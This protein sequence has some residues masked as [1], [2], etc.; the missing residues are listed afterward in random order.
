MALQTRKPTGAVPYPL[1]LVEGPEKCGKSWDLAVLSSSPRVGRTFWIDLGEGAGD[2][3]GAIP[4][5]RY[6]VVLHDGT[7]KSIIEAVEEIRDIAR[8]AADAGEPPVVIGIDS[9]TLIWDMLKDWVTNRARKAP[10]NQ[11]LLREDPNAEINISSNFWNDANARHRRLMT[12]LMTF[13]GIAVVT[14]RGKEVTAMKNGSPDPRAPKEYRV[15]GQKDLA[16]DASVWL[17]LS[18]TE[19]PLIVGARSVHAGIKVGED[20]PRRVPGLTLESLIFDI[21]KCDPSAARVRDLVELQPGNAGPDGEPAV[22]TP[23]TTAP[24][25]R[26]ARAREL[27]TEITTANSK[28]ALSAA[29][30]ATASAEKADEI[31]KAESGQLVTAWHARKAVVTKAEALVTT[32]EADRDSNPGQWDVIAANWSKLGYADAARLA[33]T[34]E[35]LGVEALP[36]GWSMDKLKFRQATAIMDWQT[37][38]SWDLNDQPASTTAP[39]ELNGTARKRMHALWGEIGYG[40]STKFARDRRIAATSRMIGR[41]IASSNDLTPAEIDIVIAGLVAKRDADKAEAARV[42]AEQREPELARASR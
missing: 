42:A 5:T 38:A 26:S 20:K 2:E 36:D 30:R 29:W 37:R 40:G 8:Q 1:I 4:G 15:E 22:T 23:T 14:A 39:N 10:A 28:D 41:E 24:A 7:W 16:F 13:P 3:Y 17:R 33:K 34:A 12:I 27:M 31:T 18:R 6:E 19:H 11:K 9:M 35:I 25:A 32:A 21:L